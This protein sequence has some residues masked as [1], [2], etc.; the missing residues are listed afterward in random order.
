MMQNYTLPNNRCF[1]LFCIFNYTDV[2][3]GTASDYLA[4]IPFD[5]LL[6]EDQTSLLFT[7]LFTVVVEGRC[8]TKRGGDGECYKHIKIVPTRIHATKS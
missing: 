2:A 3:G 7:S 8:P 6:P 1:I 4:K 5:I